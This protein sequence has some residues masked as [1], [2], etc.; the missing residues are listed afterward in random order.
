MF[1]RPAEL[2]RRLCAMLLSMLGCAAPQANKPYPPFRAVVGP[3]IIAHRGGSLEAPE[4]TLAAVRH[5]VAVGSD[6]QEIDVTLSEDGHPIVFH[7][8]T[9]E[10]TTP[11]HGI[12]EQQ[13]LQTLQA[14]PAGAPTWSP[15]ARARLAKQ[16]VTPP[17]FGTRFAAERIPTLDQVL[18]IPG[19]RLMIELKATKRAQKLAEQVLNAIRRAN[20]FDRVALASLDFTLLDIAHRLDPAVPLIGVAEDRASVQRMLQLPIQVLAVSTEI[21]DEA[22]ETLPRSLALWTWT[23]YTPDQAV[24][25]VDKGVHGLITDAPAAVVNAL[26]REPPL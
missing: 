10:R 26:R 9:L 20:A 12:V 18:A 2:L 3:L 21:I 5:G 25:L 24:A 23:V 19:A 17:N 1:T 8:D 15:N 16:G 7:D 4:N 14:L 13:S 11:G 6:W 22:L